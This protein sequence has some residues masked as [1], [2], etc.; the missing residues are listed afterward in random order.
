MIC[1]I[2]FRSNKIYC[3]T[4][5]GN[6]KF[7]LGVHF[8]PTEEYC[9][10]RSFNVSLY[11]SYSLNVRWQKKK[12]KKWQNLCET[13]AH[14]SVYVVEIL[15]TPGRYVRC[16]LCIDHHH[17]LRSLFSFLSLLFRL[18]S[19]YPRDFRLDIVRFTGHVTLRSRKV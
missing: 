1:C 9:E 12:K 16:L 15:Q 17:V 6:P 2:I 5:Y 13:N 3:Y 10:E 7:L 8:H 18:L 11:F 14:Y 4:I 19:F